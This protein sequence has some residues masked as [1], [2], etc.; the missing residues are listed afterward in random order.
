M[1]A[2]N[3]LLDRFVRSR[4]GGW[5]VLHVLNPVDARLMRWSNGTLNTGLGSSFRERGVLLRCTGAKTG[6]QR[7]IPLLATAVD[8]GWVLIASATG[9]PKNPGWYHNLK[10]NPRC[11]LLI[12]GRGVVEC[13]ARELHGEERD[14]AWRLAVGTYSGYEV[15]Q[16]R[17]ARRI[18]VMK[19][20]PA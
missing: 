3:T 7:E 15:Y 14:R 20:T 12:A 2:Y 5:T 10:A 9:Q 13:T 18:P 6:A 19:L 8:D 17:T 16:G 4:A 1:S 11:S